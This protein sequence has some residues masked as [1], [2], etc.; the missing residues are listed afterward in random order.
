MLR[1]TD[2]PPEPRHDGMLDV[3]DAHEIYWQEWGSPDGVPALYLHGGPGGTLG[4]GRYR[5]RFDLGRTRLVGFE[6]RGCGRSTP[7]ASDPQVSLAGNTTM[8]LVGDI[9][10]LRAHL[11]IDAWLVNGASW[12]STLAL[13]Y[14][15][16]H[17]HRVLGLVLFAVTTTSRREVDWITEGV[18]AIFPEAWDRFAGHAE[19]AGIGFT[20]GDG[21][22]VRAYARLLDS[23]DAAVREAA[24]QEWAL[25][26]DTHVSLPTGRVERDPRW[27]DGR[28]R[29]AFARLTTHYWSADGFCE[30]P[31]LEGA[32]TLR[33]IPGVLIHGRQDVSSPLVTAWELHRR[34]PGSQLVVDEGGGHGGVSMV[35]RWREANDALVERWAH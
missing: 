12:G 11:G 30:P 1:T 4:T 2:L 27:Q 29:L 3:G 25:W 23:A 17:P 14:A 10:R 8:A 18:G 6:Q 13:A 19:R 16:A 26:E 34:W 15:Q 28:F 24:A 33:D 22:L 35:Q 32:E 7:H 20:R 21:R 9:E 5:E 31:L